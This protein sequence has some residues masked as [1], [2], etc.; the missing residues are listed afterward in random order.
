MI[1]IIDYKVY[2]QIVHISMYNLDHSYNNSLFRT[3]ELSC[4]LLISLIAL[5]FDDVLL[6]N[7]V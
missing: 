1:T 4:L 6:C 5:V 2:R 3:S 7:V